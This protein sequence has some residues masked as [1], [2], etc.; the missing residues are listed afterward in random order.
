MGERIA[1]LRIEI[2]RVS[3]SE[4]IEYNYVVAGK[5]P[6]SDTVSI[7][8]DHKVMKPTSRALAGEFVSGLA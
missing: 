4:L 5:L 7:G 6:S 3:N 8:N 1:S 2:I